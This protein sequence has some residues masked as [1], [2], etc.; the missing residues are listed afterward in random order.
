MTHSHWPPFHFFLKYPSAKTLTLIPWT[1]HHS[2]YEQNGRISLRLRFA[3]DYWHS[4]RVTRSH[5]RIHRFVG[6]IF[7]IFFP[8]RL[9]LPHDKQD[10]LSKYFTPANKLLARIDIPDTAVLRISSSFVRF[11][12]GGLTAVALFSLHPLSRDP[13]PADSTHTHVSDPIRGRKLPRARASWYPWPG[14]HPREG[15]GRLFRALLVVTLM[16][17]IRCS[18]LFPFDMDQTSRVELD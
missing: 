12:R 18:A 4:Y 5:V 2:L 8:A 7:L 6:S 11:K 14:I 1:S 3:S 9:P 13:A 15:R 16:M 10:A 17:D